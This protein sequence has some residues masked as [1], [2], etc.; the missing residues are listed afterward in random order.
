VWT[1]KLPAAA[2]DSSLVLERMSV[3]LLVFGFVV[4][5]GCTFI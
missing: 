3:L 2:T 4:F 1:P 5:A